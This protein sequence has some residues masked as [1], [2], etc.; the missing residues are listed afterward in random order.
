MVCGE[1]QIYEL[2]SECPK[3]CLYL[4]GDYDCGLVKPL[5]T[6]YCKKGYV[7]NGEGECILSSTCGCILPDEST[8]LSVNIL[9][10]F[11]QIKNDCLVHILSKKYPNFQ[12]SYCAICNLKNVSKMI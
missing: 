12:K 3:T 8:N 6:C 9:I 1:N 5:E 11:D 4:N 2:R 10:I 7:L